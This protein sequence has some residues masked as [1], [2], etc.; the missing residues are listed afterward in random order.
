MRHAILALHN[1]ETF[2]DTIELSSDLEEIQEN[3]DN[4]S[5]NIEKLMGISKKE[6]EQV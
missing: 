6:A 5:C 2:R 4:T 1:L 3:M